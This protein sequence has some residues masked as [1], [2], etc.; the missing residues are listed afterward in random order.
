MQTAQSN[1]QESIITT[2]QKVGTA[3][4][5]ATACIIY[6]V[7]FALL[8][9]GATQPECSMS[10]A[11]STPQPTTT[12]TNSSVSS[13]RIEEAFGFALMITPLLNCALQAG[14]FGGMRGVKET[15]QSVAHFFSN[16]C[17]AKTDSEA[18]RNYSP[19]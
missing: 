6:G 4:N 9:S 7:A 3:L 19:A 1:A 12:P 11:T 8:Y 13:C 15:I 17:K 5:L 2:R 14:N 10:P 18:S 16:R